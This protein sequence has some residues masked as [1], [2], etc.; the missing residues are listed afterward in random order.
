MIITD[1][2]R[3]VIIEHVLCYQVSNDCKRHGVHAGRRASIDL[4][5]D[6]SGAL[7][8]PLVRL[9]SCSLGDCQRIHAHEGPVL[10]IA[11]W[12]DQLIFTGSTDCLIKVTRSRGP[13]AVICFVAA[14]A[15]FLWVHCL[16][17]QGTNFLKGPC[18]ASLSSRVGSSLQAP[19]TAS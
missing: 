6:E 14:L 12:Q 5:R 17:H 3:Q 4:V 1:A 18:S 11:V 9:A 8:V 10:C 7:E 13:C 19:P 15:G 2:L 16:P